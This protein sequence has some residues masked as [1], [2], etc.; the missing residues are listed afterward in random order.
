MT[1][2]AGLDVSDKST[3]ICVVD[4]DGAV[5][6]RDVVASDPDI[7]AK[8]LAKHC[9]GLVRVVLSYGDTCNNPQ[10]DTL[11]ARRPN[12]AVP[13][14]PNQIALRRLVLVPNT[15]S[16][17]K[18]YLFKTHQPRPVHTNQ[19]CLFILIDSPKTCSL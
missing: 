4:G 18:I 2:Y 12:C 7:L 3:H 14:R 1:I 16:H 5:L 8:W 10:I 19:N 15:P 6:K 11:T 13:N 9:A 17:S